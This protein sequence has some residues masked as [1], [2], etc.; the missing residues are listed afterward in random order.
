MGAAL[1]ADNPLPAL[2]VFRIADDQQEGKAVLT[3]QIQGGA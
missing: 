3:V 2:K 1:V